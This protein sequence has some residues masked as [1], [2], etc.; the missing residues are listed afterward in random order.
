MSV[1]WARVLGPCIVTVRA[2]PD[3]R[4]RVQERRAQIYGLGRVYCGISLVPRQKK[5]PG[6][7]NT[8]GSVAALF[9]VLS[10]CESGLLPFCVA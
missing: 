8:A 10:A 3:P 9:L 7:E 4:M 6:D 2:T 1:Y 5:G